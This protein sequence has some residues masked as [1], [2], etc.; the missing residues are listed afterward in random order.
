MLSIFKKQNSSNEQDILNLI[1]NIEKFIDREKN[2]I[3]IPKGDNNN[4][5]F[6]ALAS[7][8]KKIEDK[9]EKDLGLNGKMLILL[10]KMSDGDFSDYINIKTDDPYLNYF[11]KSLNSATK[12]LHKNFLEIV[13]ILKEY[14]RGSY[15]K[16]VDPNKFRDGEIKDFLK[17]INS[18]KNSI[19]K[20]LKDNHNYGQKLQ[21]TSKKLNENMKNIVKASDEQSNI[22]DE[23]TYKITNTMQEF[24]S[25]TQDA[26][27][28]QNS[29]QEIKKSANDGLDKA[30]KTATSM[31]EINNATNAISEAIEVIDQIAFQTNILSLNAA[32]EAATAGEAG[33][34]FAV[35]ASEVRN[36]ASRSA[37]A[38]KTIKELVL[39]AS[40]KTEE[41][42]EISTQMIE[43]YNNLIKNIDNTMKLIDKTTSKSQ[44]QYHDI[45][46]IESI[47]LKL[48][49]DTKNFTDI[50]HKTNEISLDLDEI[51]SKIL[52]ITQKTEFE[53]KEEN[54]IKN[55]KLEYV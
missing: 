50:A 32:V 47:I 36:L 29:S 51:S 54:T 26:K 7:L 33:K 8:A 13:K 15:L 6:E 14:E 55:K 18:L 28:M 20:I 23:I 3:D 48:Q 31:I 4:P 21:S 27:K 16:S 38:A 43:G 46:D 41:G 53:G 11:A 17:G 37:E 52:K 9:N 25:T 42:K 34:G 22:L 12:K 35:V 44:K 30:N 1:K 10:E 40:K 45:K 19:S 5:I 49:N 39:E 2:S 24:T